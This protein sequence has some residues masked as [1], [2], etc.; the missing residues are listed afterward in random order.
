MLLKIF[1]PMGL[2]ILP[3]LLPINRVGGKG[4]TFQ[5][6]TDSGPRWNVSGLDQLSWGNVKPEHSSRYW[7]HCVLAVVMVFYVCAIFFDELRGY[8]RM[9]Q[10]Y[11]TSPQHRLRASAT[12]VLVTAIPHSWLNV[13]SLDNLFDVFPGGIRNIWINRNFD[14]LNEKV[15]ERNE[16]ALKLE[17]AETDL[18]VKCKKAAWKKAKAEAKKAGKSEKEI[19]NEEKLQPTNELLRWLW[20]L[21]SAPVTLIRPTHCTKFYI[22]AP[23]R[24]SVVHQMGHAPV[25]SLIQR[26]W[27][28][29]WLDTVWGNWAK[30]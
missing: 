29:V 21:E 17:A 13:E 7:A 5:N 20:V 9:R 28:L 10:A 19:K 24:I 22:E 1:I 3:V 14:D 2:L 27:Q 25:E 26:L 23:T 15:K 4:T 16:L 8:I 18:I 11:M 12:T 6:G 30:R